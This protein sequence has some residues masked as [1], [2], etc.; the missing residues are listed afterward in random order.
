MFMILRN[1][2][3]TAIR[4]DSRML[5]WDPEA[6]ERIMVTPATQEAGIHLADVERALQQISPKQ[7]EVLLLVGANAMSYEEAAQVIGCAL[8]TVKS[9]LARGRAAL[10]ELINGE[11]DAATAG[12]D[13]DMSFAE[14]LHDQPRID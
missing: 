9:R 1:H 8:G 13:M 7:R 14:P 3:Y 5:A 4:R 11:D 10:L 12:S 2:Y 6:S